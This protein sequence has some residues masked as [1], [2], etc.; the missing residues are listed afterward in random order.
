MRRIPEAMAVLA[1]DPTVDV[2]L[3][4]RGGGSATDLDCFNEYGI[5]LR[6]GRLKG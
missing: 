1:R 4:F 5:A 6:R 2:I 3:L